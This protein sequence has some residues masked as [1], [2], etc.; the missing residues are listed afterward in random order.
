MAAMQATYFMARI[1]LVRE[2]DMNTLLAAALGMTIPF[3]WTPGQIEVPVSVNGGAAVTFI[4]DTGAE[5]SVLSPEV[6][7]S[8]GVRTTR[9]GPRDFGEASLSF[10]GVTLPRQRVMVMPFDNFR[11]QGRAIQGLIGYGL[12]E[13][14]VVSI[15]YDRRVIDLREPDDFRPPAGA[16]AVAINF[17]GRLAAVSVDVRARGRASGP[18][19]RAPGLTLT[20]NVILDTGASQSL[21]LRRFRVTLDYSRRTMWLEPN[22]HLDEPFTK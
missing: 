7:A 18:G 22:G 20:A 15:D 10:G 8:A 3:S 13:R 2:S 11:R 19:A 9:T 6:A 5:Y 1:I 14:Y 4:V 17:V 12:F 21:L 16:Q